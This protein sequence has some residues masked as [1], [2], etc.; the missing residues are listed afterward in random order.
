MPLAP[1]DLFLRLSLAGVLPV[2]CLAPSS[3]PTPRFKVAPTVKVGQ[4]PTSVVSSDFNG[5]GILDTGSAIGTLVAADLNADAKLDLAF[6]EPGDP[7]LQVG[8]MLGKDQSPP[9]ISI[10]MASS[11]WRSTLKV[12]PGSPSAQAPALFRRL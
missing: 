3:A 11:I 4:F 12:E 2:L 8:V 5:D 7:T 1:K 9:A 6:A 10:L